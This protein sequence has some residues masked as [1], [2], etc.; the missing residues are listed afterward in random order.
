L[1]SFCKAAADWLPLFCLLDLRPQ[2]SKRC[3]AELK[4]KHLAASFLTIRRDPPLWGSAGG[5]R[6]LPFHLHR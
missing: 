4:A 6:S 3:H 1:I 2:G 5:R